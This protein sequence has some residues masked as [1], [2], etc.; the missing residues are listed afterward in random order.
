MSTITKPKPTS[1]KGEVKRIGTEKGINFVAGAASK[2]VGKILDTAA[3]ATQRAAEKHAHKKILNEA[4][5]EERQAQKIRDEAL[6][7]KIQAQQAPYIPQQ[8]AQPE[9][10]PYPNEGDTTPSDTGV[11][12]SNPVD[13]NDLGDYGWTPDDEE[14]YQKLAEKEKEAQRLYDEYLEQRENESVEDL[15]GRRKW[16]YRAALWG[17]KYYAKSKARKNVQRKLTQMVAKRAASAAAKQAAQT[18]ATSGAEAAAGAGAAAGGGAVAGATAAPTGGA[19][20]LIYI[21]AMIIVWAAIETIKFILHPIRE[22][23]KWAKRITILVIIWTVIFL[24]FM[25]MIGVILFSVDA[26]LQSQATEQTPTLTLEKASDDPDGL[27]NPNQVVTFTIHAV[28]TV[29]TTNILITDKLQAY[30]SLI[31]DDPAFL[32]SKGKYDAAAKTITWNTKNLPNPA[33]ATVTFKIRINSD[34]HPPYRITNVA[35]G[36][37]DGAGG[38]GVANGNVAALLPNPLPADSTRG[39]SQKASVLARYSPQLVAVYKEASSKTGVPWQVLAGI[40]FREGLSLNTSLVSGRTIGAIEP[41]V[42]TTSCPS[43]NPQGVADGK[44]ELGSGGC[45]F[46]SLADTAIYAGNHLIGKIGHVPQSFQDLVTAV[47]RYNG[48]GNRNCGRGSLAPGYKG[49][50]PPPFFGHD[51]DYAMNLFDAAHDPMYIIYCADH[52]LCSSPHLDQRPGV[53]TVIKWV[54]T[55]NL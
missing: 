36:T 27:V 35:Q 18:A 55:S 3:D 48:G 49:Q 34:V 45:K 23:K 32:K 42:P 1:V 47:S 29:P 19:S 2:S 50:C 31:E 11:A 6:K 4:V 54:A 33:D 12:D 16:R 8:P 17:A 38:G 30:T 7:R 26:Q 5:E 37:S 43:S 9:Q 40:H 28:S 14:E 44:A 52:T 24:V 10:T 51:D 21:A 39:A 22:S 53:V 13:Y 41:D 15:R 25:I 46:S 20:I